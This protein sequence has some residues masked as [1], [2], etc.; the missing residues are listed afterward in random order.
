MLIGK[1][2][3]T[4]VFIAALFTT[5]KIWKQLKCPSADEGIKE[6]VLHTHTID[7]HNRTL[8]SLQKE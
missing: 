5:V 7:T 8:L 2:T 3:C 1:D 6:D 4:S